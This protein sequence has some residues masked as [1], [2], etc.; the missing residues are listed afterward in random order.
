[1]DQLK[2]IQNSLSIKDNDKGHKII[3]AVYLITDHLIDSDPLKQ[4]LRTKCVSLI[5]SEFEARKAVAV[6]I[7]TLMDAAVLARLISEKNASIINLE[8][9]HYAALPTTNEQSVS[10]IF[11]NEIQDPYAKLKRPIGHMSLNISPVHKE[12]SPIS[13]NVAM[14]EN[15]NKRQDRILSFIN[16]RKSAAIKDIAA[17][18]PDISEKTIQRELGTLVAMGKITKRGNKRWSLYMAVGA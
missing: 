2:H 12:K 4:A 9:R 7:C 8:I 3:A 15:K 1:M 13:K 10:A 6:A 17:L 5:T 14:F 18:F 11:K 16:D